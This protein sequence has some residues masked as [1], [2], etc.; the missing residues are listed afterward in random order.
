MSNM[1]S[2]VINFVFRIVVETALHIMEQAHTLQLRMS[3][4]FIFH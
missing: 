3:E 2:L 4:W 1:T